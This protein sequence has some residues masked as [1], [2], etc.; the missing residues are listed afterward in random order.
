MDEL[1]LR[2]LDNSL[3]R[4]ET[5]SDIFLSRIYRYQI[6]DELIDLIVSAEFLTT[7]NLDA[8]PAKKYSTT[9]IQAMRYPDLNVGNIASRVKTI[10]IN[11]SE[12]SSV[13]KQSQ[14]STRKGRDSS[15]REPAM[16]EGGL[17]TAMSVVVTCHNYKTT[18]QGIK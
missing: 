7:I 13:A 18:G 8:L 10:F 12:R 17:E 11:L 14:E 16:R 6:R 1:Y 3:I 9:K 4:A 15:G 5:Y 2:H